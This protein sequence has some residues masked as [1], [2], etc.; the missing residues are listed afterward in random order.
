MR[1]IITVI[2]IPVYLTWKILYM[3]FNIIDPLAHSVGNGLTS[4]FITMYEFWEK[5]FKWGVK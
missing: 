1:I 2:L 4:I 3:M 5:V